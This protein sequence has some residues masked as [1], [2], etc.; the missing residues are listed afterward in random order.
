M[1]A[2]TTTTVAVLF[3]VSL[4]LMFGIKMPEP[5]T[6]YWKDDRTGLCFVQTGGRGCAAVVPC[7]PEVLKLAAEK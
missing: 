7:S 2:L 4:Y 1:N 5:T 3:G 6:S